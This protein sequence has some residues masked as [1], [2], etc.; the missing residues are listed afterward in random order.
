VENLL[1]KIKI[2]HLA[3]FILKLEIK[4]RLVHWEFKIFH[5]K[6]RQSTPVV[7]FRA[8]LI[9]I[10]EVFVDLHQRTFVSF[11]AEG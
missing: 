5:L 1:L 8:F 11:S 7:L 3:E 2:Q 4:D 6:Y 10:F 9:E